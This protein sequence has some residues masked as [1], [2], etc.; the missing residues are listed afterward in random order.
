MLTLQCRRFILIQP[1]TCSVQKLW[2]EYFFS[3]IPSDFLISFSELIRYDILTIAVYIVATNPQ[4]T[5]DNHVGNPVA[6]EYFSLCKSII[7]F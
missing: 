3:L 5:M 4:I 7:A 2:S 6:V 1:C